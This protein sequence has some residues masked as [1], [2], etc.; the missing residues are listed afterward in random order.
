VSSLKLQ[1]SYK[2]QSREGQK[3]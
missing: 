1:Q 3:R 2:H